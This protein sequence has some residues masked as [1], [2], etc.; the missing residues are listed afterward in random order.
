MCMYIL[1][2]YKYKRVDMRIK[3]N[4]YESKCDDNMETG[5]ET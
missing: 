4:L 5:I 2:L 3:S 1:Y